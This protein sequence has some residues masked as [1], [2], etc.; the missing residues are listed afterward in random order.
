MTI[1]M[2]IWMGLSLAALLAITA[3]LHM[4]M[5]M[6]GWSS[7]SGQAAVRL[8]CATALSSWPGWRLVRI[9]VR[10]IGWL[11]PVGAV[12][13]RLVHLPER[14][15]AR[16]EIDG[17]R[18][19]DVVVRLSEDGGSIEI[20]PAAAVIGAGAVMTPAVSTIPIPRAAGSAS[21]MA[22]LA[23][24]ILLNSCVLREADDITNG[25]SE[26]VAEWPVGEAGAASDVDF[27]AGLLAVWRGWTAQDEAAILVAFDR[28]DAAS[29]GMDSLARLQAQANRAGTALVA[30]EIGHGTGRLTRGLDAAERALEALGTEAASDLAAALHVT[31]SRLL[32]HEARATN[33]ASVLPDAER[34]ARRAHAIWSELHAAAPARDA[35]IAAADAIRLA[36]EM[37]GDATSLARAERTYRDAQERPHALRQAQHE[38]I[39]VDDALP[40]AARER[41]A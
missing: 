23:G 16:A 24:A 33:D 10:A 21:E 14:D 4:A 22:V 2:L 18:A 6:V 34:A 11:R 7:G 17:A 26:I 19:G 25:M 37:S 9:A 36:G 32:Q 29:R 8:Y 1:A 5:A 13:L 30:A 28:L 39:A 3:L 40:S 31:R 35:L 27:L 41:P 38:E 12:R 20:A 15:A